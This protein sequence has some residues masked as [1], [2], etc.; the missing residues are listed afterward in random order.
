[1]VKQRRGDIVGDAFFAGEIARALAGDDGGELVVGQAAPFPGDDMGVELVGRVERAPV[2]RIATSRT[3]RG[4]DGD[5]DSAKV[6]SQI[7]L[8]NFG[9]CSQG[10]HGPISAP[11][12][13]MVLKP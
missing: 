8:P 11:L 2:T 7:G 5:I 4:S 3:G 6:R 13:A 1:M 9:S 12:S 10:F